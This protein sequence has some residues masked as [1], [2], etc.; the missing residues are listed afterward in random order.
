MI[1]GRPFLTLLRA[2][3]GALALIVVCTL[4]NTAS[5]QLLSPGALSKGHSNLEG[6]QHCGDCHSS[7]KRVDAGAC[8]KCHTDVG[9][10][11]S[12]GAGLHGKEYKGKACE[13]CHGE[14]LGT[15]ARLI[16]WDPKNF[17]HVQG[18]W[19]LEGAH[20]AV[21]CDKC[22]NRANAR[23]AKTFL[24]LSQTC[25]SCHKDPHAARF[26]GTCTSCH[27]E[28]KWD[29]LKLDAFDHGLSRFALKGAHQKVQCAK[30]HQSAGQAQPKYTG[31]AFQSCTDC[32][33]DVHN[34]KFGGACTK[35]HG[36]DSWKKVQFDA[37]LHPG[38]SLAN[39]HAATKCAACHDKG[40]N[41]APSR[42]AQCAACHKPV[43]KAP[44]G[45][46]CNLCHASIT[47]LNLPRAIGLSSHSKTAFPLE[48]K[49]HDASCNSCH[50]LEMTANQRYRA[51]KYAACMDCHKDTH[52][53]E[54]LTRGGG[55][56]AACHTVKGFK[57]T[58]FGTEAHAKTAYPLT[59]KHVAV[60]CNG[61]HVTA[62][63]RVNLHVEKKQCAQCHDN[64]HGNQFAAEMLKGGCA[65]CHETSTWARAKFDHSSWPLTGAH[66]GSACESCHH[67]TPEDKKLGKGASF[68]GV[69]RA[70]G[71]CHTDAH[72]GQFTQTEPARS[73][74][75]C[76][77]TQL[78]KIPVFDHTKLANYPLSGNHAKV[79]CAECHLPAKLKNGSDNTRWRLTLKQ[80]HADPHSVPPAK[81]ASL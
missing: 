61:C 1:S 56:C 55:E 31:I 42:G 18:G 46:S 6:D 35:C 20:A 59:G 40:A 34:G 50:K 66:A 74:E 3:I 71:G 37:T 62:R 49:H 72:A 75:A 33:K 51:L 10:R 7:G 41:A 38:L 28:V 30:C 23:G 19:A 26:G 24:G 4:A 36:E 9:A 2:V 8:L 78:F 76:H 63:P 52:Q 57:P 67:P 16:R 5:A 69:P 58:T 65:S 64:P 29:Q 12:A 45:K 17:N 53:G 77:N 60:A 48:G 22:H 70:C 13:G 39:G 14:H 80:C 54:F 44:F 27:N 15:G 73:C 25:G 68:R 43:H 21:G 11:I 47:W 32:H 79:Q 81:K